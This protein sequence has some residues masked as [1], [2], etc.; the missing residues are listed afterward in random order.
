MA[1]LAQ[2]KSKIPASSQYKFVFLPASDEAAAVLIGDKSGGLQN[3][4]MVSNAKKYFGANGSG[5]PK[6]EAERKGEKKEKIRK[7][8]EREKGKRGG[9]EE[10]VIIC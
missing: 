5:L 2:T 3:D 1:S 8:R 6:G 7:E 9:A 10:E 4:D